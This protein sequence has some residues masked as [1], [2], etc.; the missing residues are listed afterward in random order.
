MLSDCNAS[1]VVELSATPRP[2]A[3]VLCRVSGQELLEEGMIKLPINICNSNEGR[4]QDCLSQAKLKRE[5]LAQ[6]AAQFYDKTRREIRPIV[7]V[8]VERTGR[9]QQ[10]AGLI[11]AETVKRRLIERLGVSEVN[12]YERKVALYLDKHPEV[13][14]WYRNMVGEENFSVQGFRKRRIFP[15]FVVQNGKDKRPM[16]KVVVVESKG[17]HLA[18]NP[19]TSYKRKIADYFEKVG[20]KVTWQKLGEG[21]DHQRFRFQ[22][23]DEGLYENW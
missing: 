12:E 1:I 15:D 8:Q 14:W 17:Q 23:L 10:D 5:E 3:N 13:L 18:G 9:N 11:H 21:F 16:A 20:R 22:V 2:E 4:W 19:D 7:L 6:F